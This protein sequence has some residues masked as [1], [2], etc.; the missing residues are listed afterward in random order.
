MC[1]FEWTLQLLSPLEKRF[2]PN[3]LFTSAFGNLLLYFPLD[4]AKMLSLC[5]LQ[6][7][8]IYMI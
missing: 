2:V 8:N 5:K 6:R 4:N 3:H 7:Y 1:F